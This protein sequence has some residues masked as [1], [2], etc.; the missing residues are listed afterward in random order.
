MVAL[1][2]LGTMGPLT[3]A[4]E[5]MELLI[6]S[7]GL[8][9]GD[10]NF[11][12]CFE[13]ARDA[14]LVGAIDVAL[15]PHCHPVTTELLF[16]PRFEF[17]MELAF[18]KPNPPLYLA[19]RPDTSR[20][21]RERTICAALP[22]TWPLISADLGIEDEV[23]NLELLPVPSN[24]AAARAVVEGRADLAITNRPS[25]LRY[26]LVPVRTLK[27]LILRWFPVR[28]RSPQP[29]AWQREGPDGQGPD[30]NQHGWMVGNVPHARS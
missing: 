12:A 7:H 13:D 21:E 9:M 4:A 11:Y 26:G 15:F 14:L 30:T 23:G 6:K 25:L 22:I 8:S 20:R 29:A 2:R 10:V 28:L 24:P 1:H 27:H 5:A 3:C 16:D 19:T 17:D 18:D